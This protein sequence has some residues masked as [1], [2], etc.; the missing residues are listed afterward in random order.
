MDRLK[1]LKTEVPDDYRRFWDQLGPALKEGLLT[2]E[3]TK[4][5]LLDL[6]LA[7]ATSD[8]GRMTDLADYVGRMGADQSEIYY[9]VG[10]SLDAVRRS[11]HLEAFAAR[12]IEVLLF[13]DAVDE[14]W[15]DRAPEYQGKSWRS[16]S[17]GDVTLDSADREAAAAELKNAED[18]HKDLLG[19]LAAILKDHVKDVRLTN[20]L[21]TSA[22]CLVGEEHELSPQMAEMLRHAG[23]DVPEVKRT[24]ELNPAHPVLTGL[25][26][27]FSAD[28]EDDIVAD[29]A[30]LLL[31]QALLAEGAQLPDPA[32]FSDRLSRIMQA[33]LG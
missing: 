8:T 15:L 20:R 31:G 32:G 11:P 14:L 22:A 26:E 29:Y 12:G 5:P 24:L 27:R 21:T 18:R 4:E 9:L 7:H 23:Q 25:L 1:A 28:P 3:D 2:T 10:P 16:V 17:K 13:T 33:G 19:K 30:H 6:V